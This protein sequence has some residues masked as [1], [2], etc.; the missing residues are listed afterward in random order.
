MT[1]TDYLTELNIVVAAIGI[2][3][4][5]LTIYEFGSLRR[6]RHDFERFRVELAAEH[7]RHQQAAHRIIASYGIKDPSQ[8]ILLIKTALERDPS[9]YNGYNSL[10]YAYLEM[11]DSL[12]AADAFK[13]AIKYH[14]EDKAGYCD[15]AYAY[16]VLGDQTLCRDYLNQ[17]I[18][19][20]PSTGADIKN[21]PRF[22]NIIQ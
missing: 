4:V 15:L 10:G 12:K 19:V 6:L 1:A 5:I 22:A 21:D 8:R 14:P 18:Q 2:L 20:D 11:N 13:E 7:Y 3:F 16:L 9:V 17:A